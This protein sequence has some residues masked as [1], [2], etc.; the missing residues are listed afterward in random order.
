M[1]MLFKYSVFYKLSHVLSVLAPF[2]LL[3]ILI[4]SIVRQGINIR[5]VIV[6]GLLIWIEIFS[7]LNLYKF[8]KI[9]IALMLTDQLLIANYAN[10]TQKKISYDDINKIFITPKGLLKNVEVVTMNSDS[11]VFTSYISDYKMLIELLSDK[12]HSKIEIGS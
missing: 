9:P 8:R 12:T 2:T 1:K 7:C 4:P 10:G 3:L 11:I 6:I 5:W